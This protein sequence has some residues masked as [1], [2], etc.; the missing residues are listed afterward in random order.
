MNGAIGIEP[1][2]WARVSPLLDE[3]LELAP[4]KRMA[5]LDGLDALDATLKETLRKLLHPESAIETGGLLHTI[6]KIVNGRSQDL[7]D[8]QGHRHRAG[9]IVGGYRLVKEIGSGGMGVV[10]RAERADGLVSRPVALKLPHVVVARAGLAERMARE[11]RFLSALNHPNIAQLFDAGIADDGQPY[12]ALELVEGERIDHWCKTRGLG[13]RARLEVFLQAAR[14]VAHA[15]SLLIVHRDIK[16]A[17]LLVDAGGTVKLLDFGIAKLLDDEL[18]E[19]HA[20]QLTEVAGRA[21]TPDYA[22]PEQIAGEPVTTRSDVYALG[23]LLHELLV[24]DRPYRLK[25]GTR[26][27][28]EEAILSVDPARPSQACAESGLAKL[29]R[30][31][32]DTIVLKALK[33]KPGERYPTVDA[34]VDDIER[35]LDGRPVLARGD[36][37]A[38]RAWRFVSR[39]R[40]GV[41]ATA[42][43][44]VALVAGAG[45]ALWQARIADRE[46][47][48]A[49][50]IKD[51]L[52]GIFR[53]NDPSVVGNRQRSTITAAEILDE[54]ATQLPS[55]L[56]NEPDVKV[57]LYAILQMLYEVMDRSDRAMEMNRAGLDL[58]ERAFGAE[59]PE[60]ARLLV[61]RAQTEAWVGRFDNLDRTVAEAERI[62]A[63]LGEQR[64]PDFAH[65]LSLK[66]QHAVMKGGAKLA[67]GRDTL[68]RAVQLLERDGS[69]DARNRHV[70]ALMYLVQAHTALNELQAAAAAATRAIALSEQMNS[71]AQL[72]IAHFTRAR[73]VEMEGDLQKAAADWERSL[74]LYRR[75]FG[76]DHF[77]THQARAFLG[78]NLHLRGEREAGWGLLGNALEGVARARPGTQSHAV[79]AQLLAQAALR[80][81]R[82]ELAARHAQE[83]LALSVSS[84][85][86]VQR[87]VPQLV[88]VGAWTELGEHDRATSLAQEVLTQRTAHPSP[89]LAPVSEAH[90]ALGRL[91]MAQGRLDDAVDHHGRALQAADLNSHA[92]RMLAIRALTGQAQAALA[93]GRLDEALALSERASSGLG[94]AEMRQ[95]ASLV[96]GVLRVHGEVLCATSSRSRGREVLARAVAAAERAQHPSSR[97]L[98][99]MR[100]LATRCA[101]P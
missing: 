82:P 71:P 97:A 11:R 87:T 65:L 56:E 34:L 62:Y 41:G 23:V 89:V 72:A 22:S 13:V 28:L 38:Y 100:A 21:M 8:A 88:L 40:M 73:L 94:P 27:E 26:A 81:G 30:G 78:R 66:G 9:D 96:A 53:H 80:E 43:V 18:G 79:L 45:A 63:G 60:R 77:Q 39:H 5:W 61:R 93:Q 17:N 25:R 44:A 42:A 36:A 6:P 86:G 85:R 74:G 54:A 52:V 4:D 37:A 48:K 59:S 70:G 91:A 67:E 35:H 19:G 16:P 14:A 69:P 10:W 20:T 55:T 99:E 58:A 24:G 1:G 2:L 95:H 83:A 76:E 51:Y 12:L 101:T 3:A 57:E 49:V 7:A 29:L 33:K 68:L 92:G 50:A 15:H 47:A 32:L 46:A 31:D 90:D 84:I 75:S 98:R 64:S